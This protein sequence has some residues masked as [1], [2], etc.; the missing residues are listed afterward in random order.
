M[1]RK[2]PSECK[3]KTK[4]TACIKR[5]EMSK[6]RNAYLEAKENGEVKSYKITLDSNKEN[7]TLTLNE[8]DSKF[9]QQSSIIEIKES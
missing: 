3:A 8:V 9:E 2:D 1:C 4:C 7:D 6:I 5:Q